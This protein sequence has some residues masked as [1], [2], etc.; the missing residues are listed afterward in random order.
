MVAESYLGYVYVS[1]YLETCHSMYIS[2]HYKRV[3]QIFRLSIAY[4]HRE[5]ASLNFILCNVC[6]SAVAASRQEVSHVSVNTLD[7]LRILDS[8]MVNKNGRPQQ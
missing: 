5:T 6:P 4:L 1:G 7:S 3:F 8:R 2:V